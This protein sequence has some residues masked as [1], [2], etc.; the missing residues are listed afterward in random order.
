MLPQTIWERNLAN[1]YEKTI[2]AKKGTSVAFWRFFAPKKEMTH[3]T[4]SFNYWKKAN[5][6]KSIAL[7]LHNDTS[8]LFF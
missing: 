6:P 1:F 3:F 4:Y 2:F 8:S 5:H 7:I